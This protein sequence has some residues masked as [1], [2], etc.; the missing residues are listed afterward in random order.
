MFTQRKVHVPEMF[1][2]KIREQ[3]TH[4]QPMSVKIGLLQEGDETLLLTPG[5]IVKIERA[6][7]SGKKSILLRFSRKQVRAN[8]QHEGGFLSILASL[9]AKALPALLGG[10]ATGVISGTVE[11]AISGSGLYLSKHGHGCQIH[12]V[13]GGGLYLTPA[14]YEGYD[15]LYVKHGDEVYNGT[16]LILGPNSPF[17]NIPIL[18]L[19]L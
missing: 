19:I 10:L 14:N 12:L 11:K 5:Q 16:G 6:I 18:G 4:D 2:E 3:V 13:D 8:I 9:A 17:K 7:S 1:H 15:G